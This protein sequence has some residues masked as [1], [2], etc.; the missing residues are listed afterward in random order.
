MHEVDDVLVESIVATRYKSL[1][2]A[3]LPSSTTLARVVGSHGPIAANHSVGP[4]AFVVD[5]NL[6]AEIVEVTVVLN[7][8]VAA[9]NQTLHVRIIVAVMTFQHE[10]ARNSK[11]QL[12]VV[13]LL[14]LLLLALVV[15]EADLV[16]VQLN[17]AVVVD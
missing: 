5:N 15:N 13:L 7:F 10:F 11:A 14:Q 12:G 17:A 8:T 16:V 3:R 2:K 1:G 6:A 9:V 4:F